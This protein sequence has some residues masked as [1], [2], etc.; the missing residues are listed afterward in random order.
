MGLARQYSGISLN[1]LLQSRVVLSRATDSSGSPIWVAES[2]GRKAVGRT[3]VEA[4]DRVRAMSKE[5]SSDGRVRGRLPSA[6]ADSEGVARGFGRLSR[7]SDV[8]GRNADG[9]R[10]GPLSG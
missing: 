10:Q 8:E 7:L 5:R 9:L 3:R 1:R 4:L 6:Q 2:S